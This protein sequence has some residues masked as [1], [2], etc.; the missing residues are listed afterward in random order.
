MPSNVEIKARVRHPEPLRREAERVSDHGVEELVQEDVFFA[1]PEGRLKLRTLAP[2]RGELILYRRPDARGPKE[3]VYTIA[4]TSDPAAMRAILSAALEVVGTVRKRRLLY[5][6]GQTRI[7]LD[8]VEGLGHFVELEVVLRPGQ[9][10]EQGERVAD[11]LMRR[12][13]VERADLVEGAYLDL[14][15]AGDAH[16]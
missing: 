12:L 6:V 3:S 15:R 14:L 11:Q 13:G 5:R 7:H 1:A 9:S 8:Q 10:P 16:E 4:P 2:D